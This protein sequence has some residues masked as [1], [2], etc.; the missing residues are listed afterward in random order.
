M[1]FVR[2]LAPVSKATT[3]GVQTIRLGMVNAFVVRTED[4]PVLIDAGPLN[5]VPKLL[6]GLKKLGLKPG[7]L[8]HLVVTHLHPDHAGGLAHLK[9]LSGAPVTMHRDDADLVEEGSGMRPMIAAPGFLNWLLFHLTIARSAGQV[10]PASVDHRARDGE[11]LECGLEVVYLP[12][13]SEGHMGLFWPH[14]GGVMFVG[15]AASNVFGLGLSLG[16]EDLKEGQESLQRLASLEF[17]VAYFGHGRPI[18]GGAS[19]RFRERWGGTG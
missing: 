13:H 8:A 16:Y 17:D 4:G 2:K 5:S 15:D 12:G 11:I 1:L 14:D 9:K 6:R 18:V 19:E 7:D 10:A 3:Q